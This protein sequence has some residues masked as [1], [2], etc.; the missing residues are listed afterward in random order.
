MRTRRVSPSSLKEYCTITKTN[1]DSSVPLQQA[2]RGAVL[3]LFE[4]AV[5]EYFEAHFPKPTGVQNASWPVIAAGKHALI[6]APTGSGKTLTA[7]LWALNRFVKGELPTGCTSILYVSPLK[8]LNND[9]QVNLLAPLRAL[10]Q[11]QALPLIRAETRSGDTSPSDR[12]R[13]LRKPPEILITTPESLNLLLTT[14]RGRSALGHIDTVILDEVHS[15]IGNRRGVQLLTALERLCWLGLNPQRIALS[16]TV[17]P[18]RQ[19]AQQIAGFAR[20]NSARPIEI[21]RADQDKNIRF[22]VALPDGALTRAADG[23][24]I[25]EPLT[26]AFTE[27]LR[28]NQSTL[29]FTNSRRLAEKITLNLNQNHAA[30]LAYAHHGSLAKD[31]RHTVE[32]RLKAGELRAIVATSSLEMG[33]DIGALDEVVL[34]QTPPSISASMQRIGRSG[35]KVGDT[36]IGTL[37]PTHA[38]DF[39]EAAALAAAINARDIEPLR[40][41]H[42]PLDL[43]AQLIISITASEEW[44]LDDLFEL[45]TRAAPYHDLERQ[46]FDGV[47]DMLAGRYAG[48]RIRDLRARITLD[49]LTNRIQATRGAV[50]AFYSSGGTIP[51]RGYFKLRLA[52]SGQVIGELDEEFVWEATVGQTFNLGTGHW[53]IQ[54]ITHDDVLVNPAPAHVQAPPFWRSEAVNR[55]YHFS[56][57]IG[58]V[59]DNAEIALATNNIAQLHTQL[60]DE[61]GFDVPAADALCDYLSRQREHSGPLPGT[62]RVVLE[63]IRTG[64]G[65]YRSS[66]EERQLVIH[67]FWGAR[68]NRPYALALGAAWKAHYDCTINIQADNDAII[69]AL[70]H[71]VDPEVVV[72]LVA[73]HSIAQLLRQALEGSAFFG[74]RFRECAGRALLLTR[75][76]FNQRLPLWMTRMQSKKL[77]SA[78]RD[79]SDFPVLLES[80]RTCLEDEFD[81][82]EL[83]RLLD[84]LSDGEIA[85][86]YTESSSPSPF[87]ANLSW[88]QINQYMYADDQPDSTTPS[89]LDD[90]LLASTFAQRPRVSRSVIDEFEQKRKR[91]TPGYAPLDAQEWAEWIKERI[92]LPVDELAPEATTNV[93]DHPSICQLSDDQ[94]V[95][96]CHVEN[97]AH[98]AQ[99]FALRLAQQDR[100]PTPLQPDTRDATALV[101]E[102]LS[103]HG[104]VTDAELHGLLPH[105][106][107]A[108][109]Q[110]TDFLIEG[111]LVQGDERRYLCDIEN[112]EILLRFQRRA[113]RPTL[114][115]VNIARWPQWVYWH[116]LGASAATHTDT[117]SALERLR[118]YSAPVAVWLNELIRPRVPIEERNHQTLNERFTNLDMGWIA[119]AKERITLDFTEDLVRHLPSSASSVNRVV[120]QR[121]ANDEPTQRTLRDALVARFRDPQARYAFTQLVDNG[122]NSSEAFNTEFWSAVWQGR[123]TSDSLDS[124]RTGQRANYQLTGHSRSRRARRVS[125]PGTW[126]LLQPDLTQL[127]PLERLDQQKAEVRILLDR[128][129]VV[130][131]EIVNREAAGHWRLLFSALRV[132]ELAGEIVSGV[133]FQQLSG[134][135][136]ATPQTL[137]IFSASWQTPTVW[138][139]VFDPASLSGLGLSGLPDADPPT[140]EES[141]EE[142]NGAK[143]IT[144]DLPHR[145]QGNHYG[146]VEGRIRLLSENMGKKL[147][148]LCPPDHAQTT[149]ACA[150]LVEQ[151]FSI[152]GVTRL[153]LTLINGEPAR[154][155]PYLTMLS[156]H[157]NLHSDHKGV[158]L[159]LPDH[160]R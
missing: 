7:F 14:Q 102:V 68:V 61:R 22:N 24:K 106:A 79:L 29:F 15:I 159:E 136:F 77:L 58:E 71:E 51:D 83:T 16:A 93:R 86:H 135:Q 36:S 31:I 90:A 59:L 2:P 80:W 155:S 56:H 138:I 32:Q 23:Q 11:S 45:I 122:S 114:E 17:K 140:V 33:I 78:T 4:P 125:W 144:I 107:Y 66:N 73:S 154:Q 44:A 64:P 147:R 46:H 54:R 5:R 120:E 25:W 72:H 157:A 133:F 143:A 21:I 48:L 134:P 62:K 111:K 65:G 132:M 74:A 124:L 146:L 128:Y 81:I 145:R 69:V 129:G 98:L 118:G 82:V 152:L 113:A 50:L 99:M 18:L 110:D 101:Q 67:T 41:A 141:G 1:I 91:L 30:P 12:A 57:Y 76:R 42:T 139:S 150:Q 158:F 28:A 95:W 26:E 37:F 127:D 52:D 40:V 85:W 19:V 38:H 103:F 92:L 87:A 70:T 109:T 149:A 55:D 142:T 13:L 34:I 151:L 88:G 35:H 39:L 63:L 100:S 117:A 60:T 148:I 123:L 27:R 53:Q 115:P 89:A 47:I 84:A 20:D 108:L 160:K 43:L 116:S 8:A 96:W 137:Q 10:T 104:P 6:T 131:R 112:F 97:A 94:Q 156:Q 119:T 49:R 75:K 3:E 126:S 121:P 9:I 153:E 130:C 105:S